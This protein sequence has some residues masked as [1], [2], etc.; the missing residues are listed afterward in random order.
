MEEMKFT[1]KQARSIAG[2]T[3]AGMARLL[4]IDRS[5]YIRIE[6]DPSRATVSQAKKISQETGIPVGQIFF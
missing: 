4:G 2:K 5:T 6:K 1:V 3:Q